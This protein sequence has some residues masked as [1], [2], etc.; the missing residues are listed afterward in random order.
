MEITASLDRIDSSKGYIEGNVQWVHKSVNIMKC[1]FSSDIFIGICNQISNNCGENGETN[2]D[3]LSNNH[4]IKR[5]E[6]RKNFQRNKKL[7]LW[8]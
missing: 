4:F 1:D 7:L 6:K 2:I 5:S 8:V 3:K